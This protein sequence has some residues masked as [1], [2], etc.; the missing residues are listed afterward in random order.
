MVEAM[1]A[2][3]AAADRERLG[4]LLE[5]VRANLNDILEPELATH[6]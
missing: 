2:D 4:T 6:G 3:F 5:Q 1:L